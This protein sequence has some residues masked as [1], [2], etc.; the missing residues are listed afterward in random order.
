M[1]KSIRQHQN[2]MLRKGGDGS[3]RKPEGGRVKITTPDLDSV[4]TENLDPI[5]QQHLRY[6]TQI[7]QLTTPEILQVIINS[8]EGDFSQLSDE[9]KSR[10][11]KDPTF[12]TEG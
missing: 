7:G 3:G 5:E 6:F 1:L 11:E 4:N 8:T 12:K 10:A 9:L 2:E